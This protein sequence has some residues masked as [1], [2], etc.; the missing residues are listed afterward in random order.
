MKKRKPKKD[1]CEKE[2]GIS[3]SVE[4]ASSQKIKE[5]WQKI[6]NRI[7]GI[8]NVVSDSV[9]SANKNNDDNLIRTDNYWALW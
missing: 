9:G 4:V 6:S 7:N 2:E 8:P 1:D 3:L 5:H